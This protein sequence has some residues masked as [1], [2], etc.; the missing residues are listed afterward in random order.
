MSDL[1][2][3]QKPEQVSNPTPPRLTGEMAPPTKLAFLRR[4]QLVDLARA[5]DVEIPRDGTKNEILP[6]MYAAE[7]RGVFRKEPIRPYYLMKANRR[8]DD[9]PLD[10]PP[11]KDTEGADLPLPSHRE[12]QIQCKAEGINCF[13]MNSEQM[14]RA[15]AEKNGSN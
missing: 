14:A 3:G 15:L 4:Q 6:A 1:R 13:G 11:F 9:P 8:P 5:Y 2:Y 12:L 10:H 7:S